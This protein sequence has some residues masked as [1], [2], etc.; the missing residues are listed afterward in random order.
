VKCEE[1]GCDLLGYDSMQAELAVSA[2]KVE[3]GPSILRLNFGNC[4]L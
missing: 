4:T 1:L 2:I 3:G